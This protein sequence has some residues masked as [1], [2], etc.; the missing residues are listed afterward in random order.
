[1]RSRHPIVAVECDDEARLLDH[2]A[3][4][5]STLGLPLF[6]WSITDGIR[7]AGAGT[8][9]Y[10][11]REPAKALAHVEAAELPAVYLF[12]DLG[13][14]LHG[15]RLVRMVREAAQAADALRATLILSG[16]SIELPA[17]LKPLA[18]R[19]SL[20]LPQ[21]DEMR[22]LVLDEFR[23]LGRGHAYQ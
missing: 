8:P 23:Q 15:A 17:E 3:E 16:V 14:W 6:T 10:E 12:R 11:T 21:R 20:D 1:I 18:A 2:L 13:P 22:T 4:S 9:V 5:C 19:F 7:R